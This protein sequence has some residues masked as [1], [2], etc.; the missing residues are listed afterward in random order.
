MYNLPESAM[1]GLIGGV[2]VATVLAGVW[3]WTRGR[4]RLAIAAAATATTFVAWRLVLDSANATGL[5]V[6]APVVHASWEDVGSGL[7][8]FTAT[9]LALGLGADREE[10]ALRVVGA[11]ALAGLVVM[12]Y[13][14]FVP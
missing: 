1:F 4:G 9:A 2:L 3:P 12:V 11:A 8:A 5:D 7:L 14:I 10:P 6:D 13:D